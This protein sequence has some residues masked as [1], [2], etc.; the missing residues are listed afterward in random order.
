MLF[1]DLIKWSQRILVSLHYRSG[2]SLDS[3][4][5]TKNYNKLVFIWSS[6]NSFKTPTTFPVD[7]N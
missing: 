4:S 6:Q 5:L 1:V 2:T 3:C 7:A